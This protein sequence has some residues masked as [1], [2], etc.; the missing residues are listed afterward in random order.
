MSSNHLVKAL[1]VLHR[2]AESG[3]LNIRNISKLIVHSE[4]QESILKELPKAIQE[5]FEIKFVAVANILKDG[6]DLS[7]DEEVNVDQKSEIKTFL[8][9]FSELEG[10]HLQTNYSKKSTMGIRAYAI[11]PVV[12]GSSLK[13]MIFI[14]DTKP[15]PDFPI[16]ID[17]IQVISDLLAQEL[18]RRRLLEEIDKVNKDK[19]II[20]DNL[21]QAL[22]LCDENGMI[23]PGCSLEAKKLFGDEIEGKSLARVFNYNPK[24]ESS[25]M[26]WLI[27][28]FKD[29]MDFKNV[30]PLGPSSF[31]KPNGQYIELDYNVVR[32][33]DGSIQRLLIIGSDR[34]KERRFKQIA[35]E[36]Q[37]FVKSVMAIIK[38]WPDFNFLI[39][40]IKAVHKKMSEM[41]LKEVGTDQ[42]DSISRAM[43]TI[44]GNCGIFSL[45]SL[46]TVINH[47]EDKIDNFLENYDVKSSNCK[48]LAVEIVKE[49]EAKFVEMLKRYEDIIRLFGDFDGSGKVIS[50]EQIIKMKEFILKNHEENSDM[51][52]EF[53]QNFVLESIHIGFRQYEQLV[54]NFS[55]QL[56]KNISL[57][58]SECDVMINR[59]HYTQFFS[60]LIHVFRNAVDHGIEDK[61]KRKKLGKGEQGHIRV[62]FQ[63]RD[64]EKILIL[65]SDDGNGIDVEKVKAKAI[66]SEVLS[67]KEIEKMDDN[68]ICQLVFIPHFTTKS[69]ASD[70]SGRGVGLDAV[71]YEAQKLGGEVWLESVLGEG[72]T[73]NFLLPIVTM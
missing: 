9:D 36:E 1:S 16:F 24:A 51:H 5:L 25:V 35:D 28:V 50:N 12:Y 43:H 23:L 3:Q 60:S 41:L 7:V 53:M 13:G 68:E 31:E 61:F 38:N 66:S 21:E 4:N 44:K 58:I 15:R 62:V 19:V 56:N 46:S 27:L 39:S 67:V 45:T 40:E 65:I 34:T 30:K 17:T 52:R 47:L 32:G 10:V 48:E 6:F 57:S 69:S 8:S 64:D 42:I 2:S 70:L 55:T 49:F 73:F 71:K 37:G 26:S 63:K 20:L 29:V 11:I 72:T 59:S 18:E 33:D 22:M 54:R 14:A